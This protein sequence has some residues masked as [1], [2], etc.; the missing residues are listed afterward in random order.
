MLQGAINNLSKSLEVSPQV[1]ADGIDLWLKSQRK[2]DIVNLKNIKNI[3]FD[4]SENMGVFPVSFEADREDLL[5]GKTESVIVKIPNAQVAGVQNEGQKF[6]FTV[7]ALMNT[8]RS[9]TEPD[10]SAE[11][12]VKN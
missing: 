12:I 6:V 10:F 7:M 3:V 8:S 4:Q 1:I 11:V 9:C 2:N 5:T